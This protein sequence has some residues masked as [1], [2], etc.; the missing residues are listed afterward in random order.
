MQCIMVAL[1]MLTA[2][3]FLINFKLALLGQR[4]VT[5][6]RAAM[7]LDLLENSL[8]VENKASGKDVCLFWTKLD[9]QLK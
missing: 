3:K 9:V 6:H 5:S 8:I 4:N 2:I 7:A 1:E